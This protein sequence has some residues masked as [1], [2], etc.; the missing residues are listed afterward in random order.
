MRK[1]LTILLL[2]AVMPALAQ[3]TVDRARQNISPANG[4]VFSQA[5]IVNPIRFRWGRVLSTQGEDITYRLRVWRIPNGQKANEVVLSGRPL[6]SKDVQNITELVVERLVATPCSTADPCNFVWTVQALNREGKP[7]GANNGTSI[8]AQ[9]SA[10]NCNVNLE[11]KLRS[12]ECVAREKDIVRYKVCVS[13]TY[14]SPVYNLTYTGSGSGLKAYHPSSSPSYPISAITPAL[15]TQSSGPATTVTYCFDVSVPAT[16]TSIKI[17][18]Q[19][20][21]KDPGPIFCQPGAELDIRL[22]ECRQGCECG[23]WSDLVVENAAGPARI[24]C[25]KSIRWN[26]KRPFRFTADYHCNPDDKQCQAKISWEIRNGATVVRT[27][28]GTGAI[29]DNFIPLANGQ[30]TLTLQADCNGIKCR[31]CTYT[32][33][34]DDCDTPGECGCGAWGPLQVQNAAGFM[35][36]TCGGDKIPWKC[37]QP[38]RFNGTYQC[39]NKN[40]KCEAQTSWEILKDGIVVKTGT[41]TSQFSDGFT[42]TANGVYTINLQATCN[43]VKCRPCTYTVVVEDCIPT[44]ECGCG[45]WGPLRVQN[46]AGFMTYNCGGDKIVWKCNQQFRFNGGYQ[47]DDKNEKC[48]AQTSWEIRKDGAVIKSGTGTSQFADVFTPTTNGVYTIT[49]N[50]TCNGKKCPPCVYTVVVEDCITPACDCS[51]D[52]YVIA[53]PG[54]LKVRCGESKIFPYGTTVTLSP[55]NICG[56]PD[57]LSDWSMSVYDAQTG[58]LV[59]TGSGNG[60]NGSFAIPLNSFAGYRVVLTANCNG[61]VCTCEFWIRTNNTPA[62]C[63]CGRW[64]D[65]IIRY[66]STA[67][68]CGVLE[69]GKSIHLLAGVP[70]TFTAP[71]YNCSQSSDTCQASYAWQVNGVM[72]GTGTSFTYTFTGPNDQITVRS[73]CNNR[74]CD[75]C[76]F[77]VLTTTY[78]ACDSAVNTVMHDSTSF[79]NSLNTSQLIDFDT[80]DNTQTMMQYNPIGDF[81]LTCWNRNGITFSGARSYWNA[82]IYGG[83]VTMTFP[84]GLYTKAGFETFNFY[85]LNSSFTVKVYSANCIYT[86]T[87]YAN[88]SLPQYF[89]INL[90]T[91]IDKIE[92]TNTNGALVVENF[93]FG[94]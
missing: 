27:G 38:F 93:R 47:C 89:G 77:T 44:G 78:N 68:G 23:T 58:A 92:I 30:Y 33:I 81:W 32:I 80:Y 64:Q 90:S 76:N 71:V 39:E 61:K 72:Q 83:T 41:G 74:V 29:T 36:Y 2:M 50:A 54:N 34:V 67:G 15:Q 94:N 70:Y 91:T 49:M 16:Q 55:E 42:P 3:E 75:F 35:K 43:G 56:T 9:F 17:G 40:E 21:D 13:V 19:G 69:C 5:E 26:C 10:V 59:T 46:A 84:P 14:S 73:H 28:S 1:L 63:D 24:A 62:P 52:M 79:K 37:N 11:L 57:C 12:V 8:P 7:I 45:S 25:G 31:P 6:I 82:F 48:E 20:D 85:G 22:P 86:Y 66:N 60:S 51:K 87:W 18:L 65:N 53:N 88:P 4:A